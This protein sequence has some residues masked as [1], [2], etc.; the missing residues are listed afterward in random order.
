MLMKLQLMIVLRILLSLSLFKVTRLYMMIIQSMFFLV[1]MSV[2]PWME[3]LP[4]DKTLNS[5][6]TFPLHLVPLL[7]FILHISF[8]SGCLSA[9]ALPVARATWTQ[10]KSHA[11]QMMLNSWQF[12][13]LQKELRSNCRGHERQTNAKT[14]T[15]DI[16]MGACCR[17]KNRATVGI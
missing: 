11:S 6:L 9:R 3:L 4:R 8:Q 5:E 14:E 17:E 12:A 16:A 2:P 13:F 1:F 10:A 15:L 7:Y